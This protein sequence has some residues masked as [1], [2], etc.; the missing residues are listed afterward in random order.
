MKES[1]EQHLTPRRK[2]NREER[3]LRL[4]REIEEIIQRMEKEGE[5]LEG[6]ES[7]TKILRRLREIYDIE[8][9]PIT[10]WESDY[11]M[12]FEKCG[13]PHFSPD[14]KKVAAWVESGGQKTIAVN[15]QPWDRWFKNCSDPH[16]SPDG[17]KV[18]AWVVGEGMANDYRY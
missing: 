17:E 4:V 14:G 13:R 15:G 1:I 9:Q 18:A 11:K 12:R 7:I 5:T 2:E 8:K 3:G 16:F 10:N 6:Y